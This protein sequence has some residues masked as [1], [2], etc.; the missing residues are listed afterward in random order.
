MQTALQYESMMLHRILHRIEGDYENA[1]AWHRDVKGSE[2]FQAVWGEGGL[3]KAM[4]FLRRIEVLRKDTKHEGISEVHRLHD[5]SKWEIKTVM[6]F[7]EKKFGT[8]KVEDA[9]AIWVQDE[10]LFLKGNDM[11][12]SGERWRQF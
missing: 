3:D 4:A 11:V 8:Q 6:E 10:K 5:G 1:R 7:C 2:V 9:N 12:I